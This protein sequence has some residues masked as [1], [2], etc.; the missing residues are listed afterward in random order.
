MK[1][2]KKVKY[3]EM[4]IAEASDYFDEHDIFEFDDVRK[5]TDIKFRLKK[6]KY[7]GLD[8][9]LFKKIKSKA[10]EL[11]RSEDLLIKEWLMEKVRNVNMSKGGIDAMRQK[12]FKRMKKEKFH[13]LISRFGWAPR[14]LAEHQ[15]PQLFKNI[16]RD[17]GLW[18]AVSGSFQDIREEDMVGGVSIIRRDEKD[19]KHGCPFN[20]DQ[21]HVFID[22][23]NSTYVIVEGPFRDHE[24]WLSQLPD[25]F[26]NA[27]YYP[28]DEKVA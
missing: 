6:K 4:T 26:R 22:K 21:Y 18:V 15:Y 1:K 28:Y 3:R 27:Q 12:R 9:E 11:H 10:K 2:S 5:V 8:M 19:L 13:K 14:K 17:K 23:E 24:H 7:V 20:K 25:W 16:P